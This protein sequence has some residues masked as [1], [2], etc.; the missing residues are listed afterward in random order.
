[1]R[2]SPMRESP[3]LTIER[4]LEMPIRHVSEEGENLVSL[5][6]RKRKTHPLIYKRVSTPQE[7]KSVCSRFGCSM[8]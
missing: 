4:P 8:M 2:E 7:R 5:R 1:M 6:Q 3:N